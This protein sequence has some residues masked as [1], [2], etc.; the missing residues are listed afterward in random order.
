MAVNAQNPAS[1]KL[2]NLATS[3]L[4]ARSVEPSIVI[5]VIIIKDDKLTEFKV[6]LS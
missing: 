1:Q 5:R 6:K 2:Q 3:S 4:K